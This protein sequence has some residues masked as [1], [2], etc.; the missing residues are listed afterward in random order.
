MLPPGRFVNPGLLSVWHPEGQPNLGRFGSQ[1]K[2]GLQ[3]LGPDMTRFLATEIN[4]G[5]L[6]F[7]GAFPEGQT[8]LT[9]N[10]GMIGGDHVYCS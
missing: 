10:S 4:F 7:L 1:K 5:N 6:Q 9:W 3:N 8:S 2:K